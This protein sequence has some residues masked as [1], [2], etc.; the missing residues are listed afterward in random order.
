MG[1]IV[2]WWY[3][4]HPVYQD[5]I[6]LQWTGE[7]LPP[8]ELHGPHVHGPSHFSTAR[9]PFTHPIPSSP[10]LSSS[11]KPHSQSAPP[12]TTKT[13]VK[14]FLPTSSPNFH[15]PPPPNQSHLLSSP[16]QFC[17]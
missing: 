4:L 1:F 3:Q 7:H 16:P 2:P 9:R 5:R 6:H 11:T 13:Y 14:A 17:T 8:E 10:L 15:R 12:S